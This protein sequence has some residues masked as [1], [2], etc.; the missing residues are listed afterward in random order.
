MRLRRARLVGR[1]RL[2]RHDALEALL[3][4]RADERGPVLERV[5]HADDLV[6]RIEH[7]PE[8]LLPLGVRE[9]DQRFAVELEHVED[10]VE[11][12]RAA[13]LHG[14]EARAAVLV[15]RAHLAVEHGV[16]RA[17]RARKRARHGGE[18]LG[19]VVVAAAHELHLAAAQ[20]GERAVAV[21]LH[22]EE[23]PLLL[24]DV[25]GE[26]CEH[27]LVL[28]GHGRL[29]GL[30]HEEPVLLLAAQ[31]RRDERPK[32][33]EPLAVERH[34][35]AAVGLLLHQL[36][37]AGVPDLDRPGAVG[38]L[39]NLACE[40]RVLERVVLDVDGEVALAGLER[41][42]LRHRPARERAVALQAEVVVER[43]RLVALDDENRPLPLAFLAAER[44]R[45]LRA[46][47]LALVLGETGHRL[48]CFGPGPAGTDSVPIWG[49]W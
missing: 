19:Q 38:A 3:L 23:P 44:L 48:Q 18:A 33:L 13:L 14:R 49:G 36:V 20:V 5:R 32:A 42:A 40:G 34:G 30:A 6:L 25:L 24:R 17:D 45:R 2:L 27:R 22:L 37:G 16:R 21:P 15:D 7:G 46:V 10:V 47:A 28:L 43:A 1:A 31:L 41:N 8:P 4:D 12:V 11:E 35:Q 26:R 39:G 29:P 9:P